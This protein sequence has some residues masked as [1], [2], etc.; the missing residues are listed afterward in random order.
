MI[1]AAFFTDLRS[2]S[3][4]AEGPGEHGRVV[5]AAFGLSASASMSSEVLR[6]LFNA[7]Q[8][9][10]S[11]FRSLQTGRE[12]VILCKGRFC[13]L[14]AAAVLV[15]DVVHETRPQSF[16]SPCERHGFAELRLC[17]SEALQESIHSLGIVVND[18]EG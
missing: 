9:F 11:L 4:V 5:L 12:E 10:P 13:Q 17:G 2:F 3:S 1:A 6:R 8:Q 14:P 18:S 16:N 7:A 15:T